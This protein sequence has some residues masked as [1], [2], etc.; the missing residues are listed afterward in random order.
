M[1]N[2]INNRDE[3][4][5]NIREWVMLDSQMKIINEKTKKVRNRKSEINAKICDFAKDKNYHQ[6]ISISDGQL[7]FYEKKEY[8]PL[9]YGYVEKCLGE[10]ISDKKQ[11]EYIIQ[12]L[13]ENRDVQV[14]WDIKRSYDKKLSLEN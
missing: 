4:I 13:K 14:N 11:V 1:D 6:K 7:S 8:S 5:K 12:Y 10:L 9:T 3:F 2:K